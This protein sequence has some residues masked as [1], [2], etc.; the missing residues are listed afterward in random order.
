MKK[1]T[2]SMFPFFGGKA[3]LA[4]RICE[5]LDYDN[6][7]I[8]VEPFGGGAR[9]LLNKP[10]HDVEIYNDGSKSLST[11]M[12]AMANPDTAEEVIDRLYDTEF[13]EEQ[14]E[15][16]Q[17]VCNDADTPR[18]V[19]ELKAD[20]DY[21]ESEITRLVGPFK[22]NRLES[23]K[24][25]TQKLLEIGTEEAK[26]ALEQFATLYPHVLN[27][28]GF[29]DTL[30]EVNVVEVAVATFIMYTQSRDG[31]G[32]AFSKEKFKTQEAYY[33]RI[34]RL[35]EAADRLAG[36]QV[37]N[38]DSELFL[39]EKAGLLMQPNVMAYCDPPYLGDTEQ[40][41]GKNLGLSYRHQMELARHKMFLELAN[42]AKCKMVISNYDNEIY[43]DA[44]R[45]WTRDEVPVKTSVGG[46]KDNKRVEVLWY[47]Y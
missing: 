44:L 5:L 24:S 41:I 22:A 40:S 46:K 19:R 42:K 20:Y 30:H 7:E 10:R 16:A 3:L 43:N 2:L 47:N 21:W 4:P 23:V 1:S 39:E 36:V 17:K 35:Y 25:A 14:V 28:D 11:F 26:T 18:G 32:M 38:I 37:W 34:G 29:E 12:R 13:S 8:Y 9:V 31:M 15:S 45:N 6:T 27:K 33:K